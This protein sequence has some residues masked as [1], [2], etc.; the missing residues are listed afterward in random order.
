MSDSNRTPRLFYGW[1]VLAASFVIMFL[2]AGGRLIIGVMLKPMGAE[3]DWS[4]SAISSAIFLNMAVY[5]ASIIIT[6]RLYDRF[7]PKWVIAGSTVLAS[8]VEQDPLRPERASSYGRPAGSHPLR[9]RAHPLPLAVRDGHVGLRR[10]GFAHHDPSRAHGTDYGISNAT[11]ASML[12]WLGL[13]SLP[14]M[15]LAG[16]AADAIGNKIPIAATFALSVIL[17]VMLLWFKGAAPFWVFSLGFGFTLHATAPL[18]TTLVGALYGVTHIGFISGFITTVHM[19][20]GGLWAYLGGV[21]FDSTGDYDLAF[22]ISAAMAA[23]ALACAL[24]IREERHVPPGRVAE[25]AL[26]A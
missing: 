26:R 4:R 6:G 20:G 12:A 22:L 16:P 1:Y 17:L 7:G 23:V 19:M 13:L 8:V 3:F 14:G 18:T 11:G 10:R 15:L 25:E 21:I 5:A 9:G 2:S 24:L